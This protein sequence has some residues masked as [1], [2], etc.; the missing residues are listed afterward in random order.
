MAQHL[1][2]GRTGKAGICARRSVG[3]ENISKLSG[4][5]PAWH[6]AECALAGSLRAAVQPGPETNAA[7][8]CM[9]QRL[10]SDGLD[11]FAPPVSGFAGFIE[12]TS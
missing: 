10:S 9:V 7:L 8:R 11:D 6:G 12:T 1:R 5:E 4:G 3:A 2:D